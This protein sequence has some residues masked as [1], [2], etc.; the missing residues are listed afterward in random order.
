MTKTILITGASSGIGANVAKLFLD[1]DW[2][3]GLI[4]RREHKLAIIANN[5]ENALCIKCDVVQE[6]QI[7]DAFQMTVDHFGKIDVLFNNAG[8]FTPQARIDQIDIKDWQKSLD[9]N[10]TGMFLSAREAFKHMREKGGRIINNG[11][12]SAHTPREGSVPY[13]T[14]KHAITGL[15]KTIALDGRDLN[16]CCGQIDIGNAHTEMVANLSHAG[17]VVETMAVSDAAEAVWNM[18]QLPLSTNI[19]TMT[20]MA[21]KMPFVGRG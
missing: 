11:S 9:V 17:G 10:L 7:N 6:K 15:T 20:I 19:L 18:A 16:I 14:T 13:T 8:I 3:V 2:N 1:R 5:H 21:N 4:A 12:I